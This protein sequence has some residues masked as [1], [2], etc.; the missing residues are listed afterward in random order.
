MHAVHIF[1]SVALTNEALRALRREST[2]SIG[3]GLGG[4]R[5]P[6]GD[7]E[8]RRGDRLDPVR[9]RA[10]GP[11]LPCGSRAVFGTE[12]QTH[13]RRLSAVP[14]AHEDEIC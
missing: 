8:L 3:G 4:V 2:I 6:A 14:S 9:A 10:H 11:L 5:A 7:R 13:H 1:F 12:R